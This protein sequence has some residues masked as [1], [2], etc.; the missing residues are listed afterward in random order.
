V[1]KT[2]NDMME[3]DYP[4]RVSEDG[5]LSYAPVYPPDLFINATKEGDILPEHDTEMM[6]YAET[7][8]WHLLTGYS[9]Q[10]SYSGPVMHPCEYIGG[11]LEEYIMS[12][13]G[14]YVVVVPY[15]LDSEDVPGWCIA[16]L[17]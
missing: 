16:E 17:I 5:S 13:P 7:Q 9:G 3:I 12:T 6:A 2:L 11:A 8:G 4:V 15:M 1:S 14:V 10:Y